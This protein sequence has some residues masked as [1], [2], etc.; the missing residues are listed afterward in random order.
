MEID[1]LFCKHSQNQLLIQ[2]IINLIGI[3]TFKDYFRKVINVSRF[4]YMVIQD[5]EKLL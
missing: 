3:V 5:A 1:E 2:Q 4:K